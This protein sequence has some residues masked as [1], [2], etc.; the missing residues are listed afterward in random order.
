MDIGAILSG[1]KGKVLDAQHFDLL[2]HA[3]E[4]QNQNIEQLKSNNEALKEKSELL[5][6]KA[7][8]LE[9]E[10]KSLKATI[11]LLESQVRVLPSVPSFD[12]LSEVARSILRI[13]LDANET[14][15]FLDEIEPRLRC[16]KIQ[17]EAG[18]D[19]LKEAGIVAPCGGIAGRG[20]RYSLTREGRRLL[21]KAPPS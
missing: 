4:L 17:A 5:G 14:G 13:Y 7:A 10:N 21:A 19:E 20:M 8:L 9:K 18:V 15:M 12:G 1:I 2:K 6:E 3:Y 16:N 11:K